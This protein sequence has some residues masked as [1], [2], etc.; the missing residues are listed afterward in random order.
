MTADQII[1]FGI[2]AAVMV[3]LI[4]GRWR[5]DLVAFTALLAAVALGAVPVRGAFS[6]FSHPATVVIAMVLIVSRG[7]SNSGAVDI[8][9]R[10]LMSTAK[11]LTSHILIMSGLAA[12]LSAVMNNVGALALLMPVDLQAAKK[13]KR[14]AALTLMPLSFAS[15]LG[16]LVTLIG[17]PPNI[18]IAAYRQD[19]LGSP[20]GMFDF[21]PVGGACAVVG[22]LF[23]ALIGWRLIPKE[24][25][26]DRDSQSFDLEDYIAEVRIPAGSALAG[27]KLRELDPVAEEYEVQFLGLV[28]QGKRLPGMARHAALREGDLLVVEAG[29]EYLEKMI[30]GLKLAYAAVADPKEGPKTGLLKTEDVALAEVVVLPAARVAERSTMSLGLKYRFGV[31]L[32]GVSRQGKRFRDRLRH[33]V[34]EPGDVLLL[35]GNANELPD[36]IAWLGCLPLAERGVQAGQRGR[37]WLC[38]GIFALAIALAATGVLY[39]PVALACAAAA[40]VFLKIVPLRE[41]YEQVEWPVIVLLGSMI[42]IGAALETTG[43]TALIAEGILRLSAGA[44]PAIVLALLM[45]ITMTLSDVMNN[46]ATT[47]VAAPIAVDIAGRLEVSADPFLMTVAVAASC[48]FLTPIGHKNN[49]LIMGPGGY[50]FGDYWRMGLPL[51]VLIILV[52]VPMILLV[53]PL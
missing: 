1:I 33:L 41:V 26:A 48:A 15:I 40:M 29:P 7:L 6:G 53:W 44:A 12:T 14:A 42:P 4:W 43:G 31:H 19:V 30:G 25:S 11:T 2:L 8:L 37:A 20:Y 5:Y 32:L 23:V 10:A 16:G 39:L 13:A 35:Q 18:I 52:A 51:E 34:I 27:K 28:R 50:R 49:T 45:V 24:R 3:L 21:A 9:A 38:V 46:T 36:V 17:T 22:V 47:V